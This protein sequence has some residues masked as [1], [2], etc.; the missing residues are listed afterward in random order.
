MNEAY[1]Q[2]SRVSTRER[3]CEN[4]YLLL[5][6]NYF[7]RKAPSKMFDW[8]LN[9]SLFVTFYMKQFESFKLILLAGII[10]DTYLLHAVPARIEF[11]LTWH[12]L[13]PKTLYF[14]AVQ[15]G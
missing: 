9:P 12:F 11:F 10:L 1:L 14:H 6:V 2:P 7:L 15:R 3:F 4:K 8:V 5:T 13:T